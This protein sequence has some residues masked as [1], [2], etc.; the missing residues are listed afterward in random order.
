[1]MLNEVT[2]IGVRKMGKQKTDIATQTPT[3]IGRW[4]LT[5]DS[6]QATQQKRLP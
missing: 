4:Q 6:R 3:S 5:A 1:M 2:L